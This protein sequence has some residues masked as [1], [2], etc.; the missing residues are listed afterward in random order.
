MQTPLPSSRRST[1]LALALVLLVIFT[2]AGCATTSTTPHDGRSLPPP[3]AAA[4]LDGTAWRLSEWTL[5]SLD[6]ADFTI[7]AELRDGQVGG[8]SA[9]NSYGGPYTAGP[10][11]AFAVGQIASTEMAGPEPAMRAEAAYLTL[12][13]QATTFRTTG[14]TLTLYDRGG[15]VCLVFVAVAR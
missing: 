10:G 5:S 13:S 8:T 11:D 15:S 12:L 4:A 1:T 3:S 9:V 6:P 2:G 14:D 7:T